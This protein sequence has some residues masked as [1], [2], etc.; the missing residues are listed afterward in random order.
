MA[1]REKWMNLFFLPLKIF[2]FFLLVKVGKAA[3]VIFRQGSS[4]FNPFPSVI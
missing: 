2:H 1:G 3:L 4:V